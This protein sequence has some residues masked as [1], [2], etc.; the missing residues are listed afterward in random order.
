[1]NVLLVDSVDE[2]VEV[3]RNASPQPLPSFFQETK[4]QLKCEPG[5]LHILRTTVPVEQSV[6]DIQHIVHLFSTLLKEL[7]DQCHKELFLEDIMILLDAL[8]KPTL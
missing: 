8:D 6:A 1:M 7:T 5:C 4:V 2:F 3:W